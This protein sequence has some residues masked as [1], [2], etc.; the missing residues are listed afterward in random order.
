VVAGL[1][2]HRNRPAAARAERAIPEVGQAEPEGPEQALELPGK[3]VTA[4]L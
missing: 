1:V 2:R 3:A 4:V